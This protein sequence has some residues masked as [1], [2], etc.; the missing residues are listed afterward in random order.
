M[1]VNMTLALDLCSGSL[2]PSL[3]LS[4]SATPLRARIVCFGIFVL[5]VSVWSCVLVAAVFG[6]RVNRHD[7]EFC[8]EPCGCRDSPPAWGG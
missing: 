3:S 7:C 1:N 5:M 4:T 2:E 8:R 6:L